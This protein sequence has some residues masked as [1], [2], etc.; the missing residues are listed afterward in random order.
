MLL[1]ITLHLACT[2]ASSEWFSI[3]RWPPY[4]LSGHFPLIVGLALANLS[5]ALV[6]HGYLSGFRKGLLVPTIV[7]GLALGDPRSIVVYLTMV[8][9]ISIVSFILIR[10]R[11]L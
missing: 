3:R 2:I 4:L 1:L 10:G 6:V 11:M 7:L 5:F 9:L 8:L